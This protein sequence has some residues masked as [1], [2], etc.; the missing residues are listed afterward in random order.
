M[1]TFDWAMTMGGRK[2]AKHLNSDLANAPA[3]LAITTYDGSGQVTHP[4]VVYAADGWNS[5][6]W[7]MSYTPYFGGN[8]DYENPSLRCSKDG[9]IW[10]RYN[11]TP[12]PVVSA[13]TDVATGGFNSDPTICLVGSSMYML[14]RVTT[15]GGVSTIKMIS[16][17]TPT[18]WT[19]AQD[20]NLPNTIIS[21][22][23]LHDGVS[24]YHVWGI[25]S[26]TNE[27]MHYTSSDL[28]TWTAQSAPQ[29]TIPGFDKWH[30]D[31]IAVSGGY[32]SLIVAYP[33]GLPSEACKLF[34]ARSS[35]GTLWTVSNSGQ[36]IIQP[37]ANGWDNTHI[38]KSSFVKNR[39]GYRVWYGAAGMLRGYG[40]PGDIQWY[41]GYSEGSSITEL[42][43]KSVVPGYWLSS[44]SMS[45]LTMTGPINFSYSGYQISSSS[46]LHIRA[47][48]TG[49]LYFNHGTG[50]N[51]QYSGG[52]T[53]A[54]MTVDTLGNMR[55]TGN[56]GVG[57]SAVAT[58]LGNVTKKIEV[59]DAS[60]NSLGFIP[61]YNTI[62]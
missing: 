47:G 26:G 30:I 62:T 48:S 46:Q 25:N 18:S 2:L 4:D 6:R 34:H 58:T 42:R 20:T 27:L 37:S 3:P 31:V 7:W 51:L 39:D 52:G 23:L 19:V 54:K 57:N 53:S 8:N 56:I 35:N 61:V 41:I 50:G 14:Y 45:G 21:P 29:M 32:E 17:T 40:V 16:C 12:D 36:A 60:G 10:E 11:T 5:Y 28:L 49:I 24:T 59:F 38:Y 13:P 15:A 22:D 43:G 33:S 1:E 44:H 55:L 9:Y